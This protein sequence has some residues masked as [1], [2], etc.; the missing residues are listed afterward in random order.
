MPR[1]NRPPPTPRAGG[2]ADGDAADRALSRVNAASEV[3]GDAA[4]LGKVRELLGFLSSSSPA[5]L[6]RAGESGA[7]EAFRA[8]AAEVP[9]YRDF[10]ERR[11]ISAE[12]VSDIASFRDRVPTVDKKTVFSNDAASLC[13][14]GNLAGLKSILPSSGHSGSFAFSVGTAENA[15]NTALL[16]DAGL[17]YGLGALGRRT[18]VVNTY[19]MGV[20]VH[21]SL[22]V[23]NTGVNAD[24]ALAVI[25][26]FAPFFEQLVLIGLPLFMKRL[27]E[28]GARGG[29]DWPRLGT[30]V[31]T[32]GEGCP[33]SL[34]SHFAGL[35]GSGDA[36]PPRRRLAAS[37]M[38]IGELDLNLF[39]E[40][41]ETIRILG[42]VR[43]SPA[44]RRS[45]FGEERILPALFVYYPMRTYVEAVGPEGSAGPDPGES[46][47]IGELAVTTVSKAV[48][49]PLIRYRTGDLVRVMPW[50]R[51]A[52]IAERAGLPPPGLRLPLLAL[53]GRKDALTLRGRALR[54]RPVQEALFD[55]GMARSFTGFFKMRPSRRGLLLDVQLSPGL[56]ASPAL[57]RGL[58]GR[59]EASLPR[60]LPFRA[61]LFRF[62]DFPHPFSY[63]R[64]GAYF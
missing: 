49:N 31:I 51:V 6:E 29:L 16:V 62:G 15:V 25:R 26:K 14:G 40:T 61:R 41:P 45:L 5:E 17:E 32:G 12:A 34:R 58:S 30:N 47:G 60:G 50:S 35:I 7:V 33:E 56:R 10:L 54:P 3:R 20:Q 64:K 46:S 48:R 44:L 1:R 2:D 27:L 23:A 38:G 13:R 4:Y 24:I 55:P 59:L 36:D 11:G 39:H 19:P 18:L 63:E 9:W 52:A 37:S 28:E 53:Y 8:A 21:S 22:P 43:K 57:R 42:A